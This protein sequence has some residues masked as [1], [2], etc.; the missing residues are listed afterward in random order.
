M[1]RDGPAKH[2]GVLIEDG[3]FIHAIERHGVVT[4]PHDTN[5]QRRTAFAF[6]FPAG[7]P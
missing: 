6:L 7:N 1:R 2:C 4:V 5:W 3:T